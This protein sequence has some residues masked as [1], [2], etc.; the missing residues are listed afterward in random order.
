MAAAMAGP[1]THSTAEW[2]VDRAKD[3]LKQDKFY[4]AKSWLLTAKTLYPRNFFIQHEAYNI[5]RN[6]RRVKEAA[7]LFCEMFEQF[8][9]ESPL[10]KDIFHII[11]ALENDK[12]DV[13][14]E[15]L[16]DMFN[17]LPEHVQ[18]EALLQASGRC[19]DCIEK[20]CVMLLL[21]RRFPDAIP[22]NGTTLTD[23]LID[24]EHAEYPTNPINS[25]RRLLVCDVLP[26]LLA[27][28]GIMIESESSGQEGRPVIPLQLVYKWLELSIQFYAFCGTTPQCSQDSPFPAES[29]PVSTPSNI[30]EIIAHVHEGRGPWGAM[31]DMFCL[32]AK[33]CNWTEVSIVIDQLDPLLHRSTRER[34]ACLLGIHQW[35]KKTAKHGT[36]EKTIDEAREKAGLFYA[37]I[38]IFVQSV[39]EYCKAV[40]RIDTSGNPCLTSGPRLVLIEDVGASFSESL[41]PGETSNS[42]SAPKK[43]KK[44]SGTSPLSPKEDSRSK[45]TPSVVVSKSC[46]SMSSS[47]ADEFVVA[48]DSWQIL[49]VH[50]DYKTEFSRILEEWNVDQWLWMD[51][52]NMDRMIYKAKYKKVVEFLEQQKKFFQSPSAPTA[53]LTE[54]QIRC[55]LQLSC[56]YFYQED[57]K[58]ACAEVLDALKIFPPSLSPNSAMAEC[59][60]LKRSTSVTQGASGRDVTT[61]G[62]STG[63]FLQLIPCTESEVLSFCIR[64]LITCF[65]LRI[66]QESRT[67]ISNLFRHLIVLLQYDWP[68]E[69]T[70]FYEMLE[71]IRA[72]GG[73]T[74]RSFFDYVVNMLEEFAHMNNEGILKLDFLPKSSSAT[75]ARTVTRGVN[76]GVKEDFR[77]A[78]EK[79][80]MRSDESI[81]PLLKGF[82]EEN[83]SHIVKLMSP[84]STS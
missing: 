46:G 33:K 84:A 58:S 9:D 26:H 70:T 64:L 23:I 78:M 25:Y 18:R 6:A 53:R 61:W 49:N 35:L 44:K 31:Y 57:Y 66:S 29:T 77:S 41:S 37:M 55:S 24:A 2:L 74:Y 43:K 82:F 59:K 32:I 42:G 81:E 45:Q 39:W 17:C 60:T 79:Q 22:K 21:L 12:P 51:S 47:L 62:A 15:F 5:E 50:T 1:V 36:G 56:C 3:S 27:S 80:V 13:K 10:W 34:W 28:D 72:N 30:K 76:K 54:L 68:R 75:R 71:K 20:C 65:K 67:S 73:L 63:R 8:P 7:D 52:F 69:E 40:N 16:K 11:G 14:G 38:I 83:Q 4:E 19:K 48:V